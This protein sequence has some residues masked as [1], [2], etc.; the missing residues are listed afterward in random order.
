MLA[1]IQNSP[2]A[3]KR[4]H[5]AEDLGPN[6]LEQE[7]T[8]DPPNTKKQIPSP[9]AP[10][11]TAPK[12]P[13]FPFAVPK[14][15][16]KTTQSSTHSRTTSS[17]LNPFA[18]EFVFRPPKSAPTLESVP[19]EF[20]P[21]HLQ[22]SSRS[23]FNVFAPE[24]NPSNTAA[25]IFKNSE[26]PNDKTT[27]FSNTKQPESS[28]FIKPSPTKK[29]IPIVPPVDGN[30]SS[31]DNPN[32]I[33]NNHDDEPSTDKTLSS[34]EKLT[35]DDDAPLSNPF[36]KQP[37]GRIEEEQESAVDDS[38]E[39]TDFD[40][41]Y[42]SPLKP[43]SVNGTRPRTK[44]Q[45]ENSVSSSSSGQALENHL[46]I[47]RI[48]K[49]HSVP[50]RPVNTKAKIEMDR[51]PPYL[52][53]KSSPDH[54]FNGYPSFWE[55]RLLN[56]EQKARRDRP[57]VP[58]GTIAR[59]LANEL[60]DK[61]D[62]NEDNVSD[63]KENRIM[64]DVEEY[65]TDETEES[66][67]GSMK[68]TGRIGLIARRNSTVQVEMI[69]KER[70]QPVLRGL[71]IVQVGLQRLSGR[72]KE[73]RRKE[74]GSDADDEDDEMTVRKPGSLA[75]ER[76]KNAVM[77][78]LRQEKDIFA[79]PPVVV[80][81]SA[82]LKSVI[83]SLKSKLL[84]AEATLDREER[85]RIDAERRNE[86]LSRDLTQFEHN[87]E[88]KTH[89][90][91]EYESEVKELRKSYDHA[92]R[93]W[94]NERHTSEKL[95][96]VIKGIRSS[97]G[98]MT[99]KNSK[100]SQEVLSLQS[101]TSSQKDDISSLREEI[102]KARGENGKLGR[103]R[104]K[105]ERE[106]EDERTRFTNLQ[107]ELMETG[108]AIAEQETRWREELSTE[109]L[110]VQSLERSLSD[111]ERRFKK[112]EEECEKLSKIAEERG[113]LKAMVEAS[114]ARERNLE[115]IK[116][117]LE[118]RLYSA[119]A[120]ENVAH[121]GRVRREKEAVIQFHKEKDSLNSEISSLQANLKI[122]Q[123]E[124]TK[125][126]II[127]GRERSDLAVQ[128]EKIESLGRELQQ[129]IQNN[130]DK[131]KLIESLS[132]Q[133]EESQSAINSVRKEIT[134]LRETMDKKDERLESLREIV[135][136]SRADIAQKEKLILELEFVIASTTSPTQKSRDDQSYLKLQKREKEILRLRALMAA[137]LQDNED[138]LAQSTECL[139]PDQQKKY[140]VMKN[141][142]RAERE[143]RKAVEKELARASAKNSLNDISRT[144]G[145]RN[146][147]GSIFET[148][149]SGLD[150]PVSLND[151]FESSRGFSIGEDTPLKGKGAFI[152]S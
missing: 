56:S 57:L 17:S 144:P 100:L 15:I 25:R 43:S 109:K 70:L 6:S 28:L 10:P 72:D 108:K 114:V 142:L 106:I 65:S 113:K 5:S 68:K 24:F 115:G 38:E 152:E 22:Q 14:A 132:R 121:E 119:E 96:E 123:E 112:M 48:N 77:E 39:I 47:P 149:A 147:G 12:R 126:S 32:E 120:R 141:I 13:P 103:E 75:I 27:V 18:T 81:R 62:E 118:K 143:R 131:D 130:V 44:G 2:S 7:T 107:N 59:N 53:I 111:E 46:S 99:D 55:Q 124:R 89:Q 1:A 134:T 90:L 93:G 69:I 31:L 66:V 54:E 146:G 73:E 97:L 125:A 50:R 41:D 19:R 4:A 26:L 49:P 33:E 20:S 92:K 102:S 86:L 116:E 37:V 82:E 74:Q 23:L 87:L 137:L 29:A 42:A 71:E 35:D 8:D 95:D 84:D 135:D 94:D 3:R 11:L 21:I 128:S 98:Q 34:P 140:N 138:L 36:K 88:S 129:A 30:G 101:L 40:I 83:D 45:H 58:H 105:L 110:R 127:Y 133:L 51:E 60:L 67:L 78:A 16:S 117:V 85:R 9:M 145:S 52:D 148:P 64:Q 63:D 150:T 139:L 122:L 76:I 104:N 91:E 61:E 151:A 80:D 79:T 136:T